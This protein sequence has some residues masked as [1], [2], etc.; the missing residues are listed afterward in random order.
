MPEWL[1]FLIQAFSTMAIIFALYVC[2][3]L[4]INAIEESKERRRRE[5]DKRIEMMI[6]AKLLEIVKGGKKNG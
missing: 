4:A 5:L 3:L 6:E 1:R 2:V